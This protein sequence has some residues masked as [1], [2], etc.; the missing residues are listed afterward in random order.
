[1]LGY[2]GQIRFLPFHP[3]R[4]TSDLIQRILKT[5]DSPCSR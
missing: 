4:S 5:V 3:G 1:V 2:G